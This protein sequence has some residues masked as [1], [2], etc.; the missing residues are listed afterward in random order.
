LNF[1]HVG[2]VTPDL[3]GA[4]ALY[5]SLGYEAS[6]EVL[7]PIQKARIVLL[8]RAQGPIVE[9]LAP[10]EEASPLSGWLR[11]IQAG[12]YHTCYE[13][14][15]AGGAIRRLEALGMRLVSGPVPAV[16]F[17]GRRVAF[18]WSPK[19]GLLE[20]LERASG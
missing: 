15:D 5:R 10:S 20:V 6:A 4:A 9:L 7:D 13:A 16:A 18:L 12:A 1:H 2:V 14:P 11:R 3:A 8:S 19:A 17:G